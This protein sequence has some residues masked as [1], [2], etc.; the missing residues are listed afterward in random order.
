MERAYSRKIPISVVS[1][2]QKTNTC[3]SNTD[4]QV[5]ELTAFTETDHFQRSIV[6]CHKAEDQHDVFVLVNC[7]PLSNRSV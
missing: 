5:A 7:I 3:L 6:Y 4:N 2:V 1:T